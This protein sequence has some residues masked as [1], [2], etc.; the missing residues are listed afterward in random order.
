[1]QMVLIVLFRAG[2]IYFSKTNV[3]LLQIRASNTYYLQDEDCSL[4]VYDIVYFDLHLS[5]FQSN[6]ITA[7]RASNLI[8]LL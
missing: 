7:L 5:K 8:F 2:K 4:L 3:N 6:L 1:M